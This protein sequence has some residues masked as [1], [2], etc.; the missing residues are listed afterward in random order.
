MYSS[1]HY[2]AHEIENELVTRN[3]SF[4]TC[5]CNSICCWFVSGYNNGMTVH[6]GVHH[7]PDKLKRLEIERLELG[8][9]HF[10]LFYWY[11]LILAV[12]VGCPLSGLLFRSSPK[13]QQSQL[14]K[15]SQ[16][17]QSIVLYKVSRN[18]S[19]SSPDED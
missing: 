4:G 11:M 5:M 19:T 6:N 10:Y 3:I 18:Q 13:M 9:C 16:S 15:T 2:D 17:R 12:P 1:A 7:D 14:L 8:L